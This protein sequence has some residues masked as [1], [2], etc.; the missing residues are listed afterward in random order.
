MQAHPPVGSVVICAET[1]KPFTVAR[2]GCSYNYATNKA[3]EIISDKGVD[4]R[5]RRELS[6]RHAPFACYVSS[7][8]DHVTGWKGN[9]LGQIVHSSTICN[10]FGGHL[11]AVTVRDV[12]GGYWHGRGAGRGMSILLRPSKRGPR[13][14]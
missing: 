12:H 11:L 9:I 13:H 5:E 4:I 10:P 14:A 3:G 2:D 1:K 8:G 7:H 6:H